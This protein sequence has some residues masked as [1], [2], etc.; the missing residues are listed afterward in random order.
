M[1]ATI[2]AL[3]SFSRRSRFI[4]GKAIALDRLVR[5]D[6][7]GDC[8]NNRSNPVENHAGQTVDKSGDTR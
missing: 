5:M 7:G 1:V 3:D 6:N 4:P 2:N 8:R